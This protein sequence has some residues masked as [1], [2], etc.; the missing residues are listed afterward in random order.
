VNFEHVEKVKRCK[1]Y[2]HQVFIKG[3]DEPFIISRR[4]AVKL[5]KYLI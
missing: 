1:N 5:K 4:C 2:T 3:I